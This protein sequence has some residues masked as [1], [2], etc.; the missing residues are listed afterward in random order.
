MAVDRKAMAREYKETPRPMGVFRVL[1]TANGKSLVGT[2]V[3]LPA[4][5]NRQRA[6]LALG[7]HRLK[8]LQRDWAT[9]GE[10]A[11][12]FE[13]LDTLEPKDEPGWEPAADLA[14]LE[15]LWIEKLRSWGEGGYNRAPEPQP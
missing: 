2:S 4:M 14:V 6:Q 3:D 12:R 15:A 9:H 8:A 7:G 13:V 11:F 1:C 5:L 10:A